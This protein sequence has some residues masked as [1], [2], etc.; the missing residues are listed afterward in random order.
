ML[1]YSSQA[2]LASTSLS[3]FF[4]N[5]PIIAFNI[6]FFNI[7]ISSPTFLSPL[8]FHLL[9]TSPTFLSSLSFHFP[10]TF[11]IN[12]ILPLSLHFL[13]F[14]FFLF[15]LS[16]YKVITTLFHSMHSFSSQKKVISL[17]LSLSL[18]HNFLV[19]FFFSCISVLG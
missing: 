11:Y 10:T 9:T 6:Y 19:N 1:L 2:T 8:P 15:I 12:I 3:F 4:F 5:F 7:Y 17:S 13:Y 18:S 14:C 16:Y